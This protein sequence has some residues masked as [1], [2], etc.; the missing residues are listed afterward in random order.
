MKRRTKPMRMKKILINSL[1]SFS[2]LIGMSVPAFAASTTYNYDFSSGED[3]REALGSPTSTD[4]PLTQDPMTQNIRRNK[5]AA[6]Y[7]PSYGVF[8]GDIPTDRTSLYHDN[9]MP[10]SGYTGNTAPG[11]Y[12]SGSAG[13]TSGIGG[14]VSPVTGLDYGGLLPPTSISSVSA[15][16]TS[17]QPAYNDDGS[18][19]TLSIP[20]LGL[21]VKVYEGETLENMKTGVG[22]FEFTSAW[23]GNVAIAGHNRGVPNAI[24]GIKDLKD[25]EEIIYKTRY[26]TR[27][28]EV[29]SREKI[30][31]NDYSKFGWSEKN[32]LTMITCVKNTPSMR[33]CVQAREK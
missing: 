6:Y 13:G 16:I 19:G 32:I 21:T 22:H 23:D 2:M 25:G 14:S 9:S 30:S 1:L 5:D 17:T 20:K 26:G 31:D 24:G 7:P 10:Y 27:T 29:F 28:Y 8:S 15:D 12:G 11:A 33:W 4:N 3:Y 18:I